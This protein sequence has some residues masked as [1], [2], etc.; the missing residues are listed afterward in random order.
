MKG[1]FHI[2]RWSESKVIRCLDPDGNS[3]IDCIN[4]ETETFKEGDEI[5]KVQYIG[6]LKEQPPFI[7]DKG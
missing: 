2:I 5:F 3:L 7:L 1:E 6:A 4:D